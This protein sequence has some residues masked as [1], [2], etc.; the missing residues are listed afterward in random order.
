MSNPI[1]GADYGDSIFDVEHDKLPKTD[2][3]KKE[4]LEGPRTDIVKGRQ[5]NLSGLMATAE[6]LR[7]L[8]GDDQLVANP[9][10]R[11]EEFERAIAIVDGLHQP[12]AKELSESGLTQED[13]SGPFQQIG[14][15]RDMM[16]Q[17]VQL[18]REGTV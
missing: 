17:T 11:A 14:L 3:V 9:L 5:L 4:D 8:F 7:N 6:T 12:T 1:P 16:A 13:I 18:I 15:Y 2:I 10:R